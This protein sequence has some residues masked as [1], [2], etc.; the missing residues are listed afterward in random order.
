LSGTIKH[1]DDLHAAHVLKIAQAFQKLRAGQMPARGDPM[2]TLQFR[3][4]V[5]D[6]VT[7]DKQVGQRSGHGAELKG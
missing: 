6:A 5:D 1:N 3:P 4:G 7:V 2:F